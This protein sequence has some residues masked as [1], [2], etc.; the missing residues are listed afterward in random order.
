RSAFVA[1]PLPSPGFVTTM[2][3]HPGASGGNVAVMR[4]ASTTVTFVAATPLIVTLAADA[5][6]PPEIVIVEPPSLVAQ[7]GEAFVTTTPLSVTVTFGPIAA[8]WP[9]ALR[10]CS[11]YVPDGREGRRTTARLYEIVTVRATV[12]PSAKV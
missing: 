4:V 7:I 3:A 8:I 5:K 6:P 11:S 9:A 10:T 2:V 12:S 1:V